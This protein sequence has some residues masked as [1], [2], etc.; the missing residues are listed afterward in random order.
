MAS[1]SRILHQPVEIRGF[2]LHSYRKS[3]I[4]PV[5]VLVTN[6][7]YVAIEKIPVLESS[8]RFKR[9]LVFPL[10]FLLEDL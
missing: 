9:Y 2:R 3:S 5:S 7:R 10:F 1:S 6:S 4:I 8:N